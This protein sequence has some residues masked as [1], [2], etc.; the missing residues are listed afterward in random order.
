[1]FPSFLAA[2][3]INNNPNGNPIPDSLMLT[4]SPDSNPNLRDS[5]QH[6]EKSLYRKARDFHFQAKPIDKQS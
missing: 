3:V 2:E 6:A 1:M 4:V 5:D